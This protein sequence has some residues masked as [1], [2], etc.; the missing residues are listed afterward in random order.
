MKPL[1]MPAARR[2]FPNAPKITIQFDNAPGHKTTADDNGKTK[3]A[4]TLAPQMRGL[5]G[6]PEIVFGEQVANSPDTNACD[7]GFF[8]SM[9]LRLPKKRA[10]KLDAFEHRRAVHAGLSRVSI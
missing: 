1:V 7:L 4:A 8:K 3:L 10:L 2:A 9:D 5:H 6:R